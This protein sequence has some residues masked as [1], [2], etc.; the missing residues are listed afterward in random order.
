[1]LFYPLTFSYYYYS[2]IVL[3]QF[4]MFKV[5]QIKFFYSQNYNCLHKYDTLY[6]FEWDFIPTLSI[7]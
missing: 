7:I 1:M 6:L 5:F 2:M 3:N 4:K